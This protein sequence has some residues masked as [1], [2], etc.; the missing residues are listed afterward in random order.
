MK[1]SP[2][3][4]NGLPTSATKLNALLVGQR[5]HRETARLET[6]A[7]LSAEAPQILTWLN[8]MV[9]VFPGLRLQGWGHDQWPAPASRG[10]IRRG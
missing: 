2:P 4:A 8:Q 7:R 1:S 5:K 9:T 10:I 3:P 6:R